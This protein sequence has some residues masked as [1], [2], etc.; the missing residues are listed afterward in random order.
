[1][2][3][4]NVQVA[5]SKLG[6]VY[7]DGCSQFVCEVLGVKQKSTPNWKVGNPVHPSDLQPGDVVGWPPQN[8]HPHGHV[9]IWD[10]NIF[11]NCPGQGKAV[12]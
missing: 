2:V 6:K 8:G 9:V 3:R 4:A 5:R 1:M 10:G 12:K 11:L 7:P